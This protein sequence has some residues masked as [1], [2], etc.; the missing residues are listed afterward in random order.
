MAPR[1][2]SPALLKPPPFYV[3]NMYKPKPPPIFLAIFSIPGTL[4][5]S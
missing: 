2:K 4:M 3:R 5:P 1:I